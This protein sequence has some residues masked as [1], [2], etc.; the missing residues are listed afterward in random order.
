MSNYAGDITPQ[1]AWD[2]LKSNEDAV[3][4]DVR[5][6]AEWRFVG[7]PDTT[8][9]GKEPLFMSG[10]TTPMASATTSSWRSSRRRASSR[11]P[12]RPSC[13][14]A[15]RA[16]APSAPPWPRPTPASPRRTTSSRASRA[17]RTTGATAAGRAGAPPASPG[18]RTRQGQPRAR[19]RAAA[20][21]PS[22]T[23]QRSRRVDG[24]TSL[25]I[26]ER[27]RSRPTAQRPARRE[28]RRPR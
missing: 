8:E 21:T 16:S 11:A 2:L 7:V 13:S 1:E 20:S 10:S 19:A 22:A 26:P 12:T 3:L 17:R 14:C 6:D 27:R 28:S 23:R 18:A 24:P 15:A 5:T 4:V 9:A 25:T